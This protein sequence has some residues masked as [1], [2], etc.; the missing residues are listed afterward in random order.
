[1]NE[2]HM[3]FRSTIIIIEIM[4]LIFPYLVNEITNSLQ[5]LV[6]QLREIDRVN[7]IIK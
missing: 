7:D 5:T 2:V 1:M 6:E 4:D 3:K